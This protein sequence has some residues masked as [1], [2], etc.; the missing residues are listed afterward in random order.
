MALP[1]HETA[2]QRNGYQVDDL[3]FQIQISYWR[4]EKRKPPVNYWPWLDDEEFID[5]A[6][7]FLEVK[8]K[9]GNSK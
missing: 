4:P 7:M 2:F 3:A 6:R 5:L 9:Y 8:D 1:N